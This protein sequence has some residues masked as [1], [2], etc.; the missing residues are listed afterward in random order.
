MGYTVSSDEYRKSLEKKLLRNEIKVL[1]ATSAL[2]MGFDKPDLGFVI[3]YQAPGSIISY[4]QQVG[5]AGRAI[6]EAYGILLSGHED[7]DIHEFFRSSS[8]PT[9]DVVQVILSTLE[10]S[11]NGLS[12]IDLQKKLNLSQGEVAKT[13]KYLSVE[14]PSPIIKITFFTFS[15]AKVIL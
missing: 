2:G 4:Y 12:S 3:H 5:R 1:V 10:E 6:D 7:D 15:C 9:P 13:L 14:N 8:F 11:D